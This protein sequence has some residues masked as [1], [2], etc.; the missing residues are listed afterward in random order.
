MSITVQVSVGVEWINDFH[1]GACNQNNLSYCNAQAE[2]FYNSMGSH[3]HV[4]VFDWGDDN[5][6]ETDFR[7]PDFG[8]DSL[9]WSDNV[10]F[11][12]FDDH[13]GNWANV[14]H[15]AFAIAHDR[16]LG[17]STDWRLGSKSMKWFVSCGCETVLNTDPNHIVAVWGGPMQ[18]VHLVLGY[19]GDSTD[20]WWTDDLGGDFADDI[21]GGEV[22]C[23][24]WVDRAYSWWVGDKSIAI[25]AGVDQGDA[26]NRREN[27]TLNWRDANIAF[28]G[29]LAWKWRS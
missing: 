19:I 13:G 9:N 6:W 14:L 18:G 23:Q 8:G 25:A 3:G 27:E 12:F 10:N 24:S 16:C 21:C 5:A 17:S 1:P 26:E 22:I 15:I 4:R 29:W 7:H 11:C 20:S 2:G 28:T